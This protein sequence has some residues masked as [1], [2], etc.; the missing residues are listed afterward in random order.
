MRQINPVLKYLTF[1]LNKNRQQ[2]LWLLELVDCFSKTA[3][4]KKLIS[5]AACNV[6]G[7]KSGDPESAEKE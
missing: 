6:S 2:I 5:R 1:Y 3:E 4:T 7:N